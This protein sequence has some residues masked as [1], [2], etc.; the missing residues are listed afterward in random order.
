VAVEIKPLNLESALRLAL[1]MA[2]HIV[3]LE[4]YWPHLKKARGDGKLLEA[5]LKDLGKE[6]AFA[7]GDIAT[8]YSLLLDMPPE[9]IAVNASAK[10]LIEVLPVLD[11]VNDFRGLFEA[12]RALGLDQTG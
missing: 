1:L 9:W 12:V 10:E 5:I 3:R 8:A 4:R 11:Q 7:P 6:L 2:P